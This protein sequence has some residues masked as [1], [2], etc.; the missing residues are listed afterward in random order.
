MF[1]YSFQV[2]WSPMRSWL[3]EEPLKVI[4]HQVQRKTSLELAENLVQ[5]ALRLMDWGHKNTKNPSVGSC[6]Q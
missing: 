2:P 5:A 3:T 4:A 1:L 6:A